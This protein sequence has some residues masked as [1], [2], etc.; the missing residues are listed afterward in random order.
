MKKPGRKKRSPK[1]ITRVE[2]LRMQLV[3]A[4]AV[5]KDA[6]EQFS[7][8]KRRRKLAKLL[9]RRAKTDVKRAKG[10]FAKAR[11]ALAWAET[12]ESTATR[13]VARRKTR[14]PGTAPKATFAKKKISKGVRLVRAPKIAEPP[15]VTVL[16]EA[17]IR[18]GND[19]VSQGSPPI[20]GQE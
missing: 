4:E 18:E 10:Q 5:W 6:K 13:Q 19:L 9:A 17:V 16:A 2:F 15:P 8:A 1:V 12:H 14:K 11:E 3:A 20:P 7:R